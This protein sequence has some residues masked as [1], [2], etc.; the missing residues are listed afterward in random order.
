[1][2]LGT[3]CL[4]VLEKGQ[5]SPTILLE[6]GLMST[7]LSWNAIQSTLAQSYR[8]VSYASASR[9]SPE[10]NWDRKI[11][12]WTGRLNDKPSAVIAV[13]QLPGSNAVAT[14][15]GG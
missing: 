9:T 5:G 2:G 10:W 11:T 1:M 6:A 15:E 8:V 4:H 12:A 13:Y 14:A 3:H 7:V